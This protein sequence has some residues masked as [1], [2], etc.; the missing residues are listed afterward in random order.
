MSPPIPLP[1][2]S[3]SLIRRAYKSQISPLRYFLPSP[4]TSSILCSLHLSPCF[5]IDV[6]DNKFHTNMKPQTKHVSYISFRT[7]HCTVVGL[8]SLTCHSYLH[9]SCIMHMIYDIFVI[10]KWGDTRPKTITRK[11]TSGTKK[12]F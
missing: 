7:L 12:R 2:I 1:L 5:S 3:F 8:L 11:H 4:V 9:N 6:R 10:C